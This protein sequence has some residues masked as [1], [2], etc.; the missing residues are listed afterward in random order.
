[1]T[2]RDAMSD[3]PK[4]RNGASQREISYEGEPQSAFQRMVSS[5]TEA[6]VTVNT[7][8][9]FHFRFEAIRMFCLTMCV[10]S[11]LRWLQ[12][13]FD[14]SLVILVLIGETCQMLN[15]TCQTEMW[16]RNCKIWWEGGRDDG[17]DWLMQCKMECGLR[18]CVSRDGSK[19]LDGECQIQS[20]ERDFGQ[21]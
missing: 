15:W 2:V 13:A 6:D 10:K 18:E 9:Y 5:Y 17:R 16:Q 20:R 3:L 8:F 7:M 19:R 14:T 11:W 21:T 12:L 1:M 4:I